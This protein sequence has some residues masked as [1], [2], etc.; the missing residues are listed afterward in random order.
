MKIKDITKVSICIALLCV[1]SLISIPVPF[2]AP[3]TGQTLMVNI[4]AL[5][6]VPKYAFAAIGG[7]LLLGAFGLPVFSGGTSGFG[8]LVGPTG[9]YLLGFLVAAPLISYLKGSLANFKRYAL[10]SI[11]VGMPIIYIIGAPWLGFM[12]GMGLV[13]SFLIGILPFLAGD[14][15][16]CIIGAFLSVKIIKRLG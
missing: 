8:V 9:G 14:I 4:I 7:Y 6:L 15:I 10:V 12:T 11:F 16:K 2:S 1:S 13:K 3:I 5:I